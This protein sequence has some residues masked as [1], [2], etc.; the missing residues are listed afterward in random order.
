MLRI[1]AY[2]LDY[3]TGY[4]ANMSHDGLRPRKGDA[5]DVSAESDASHVVTDFSLMICLPRG[6]I[7]LHKSYIVLQRC[8]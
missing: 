2:T 5:V 1:P 6:T 7:P 3:T 8:P 4:T